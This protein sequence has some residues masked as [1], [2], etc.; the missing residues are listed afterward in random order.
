MCVHTLPASAIQLQCAC[1]C[2]FSVIPSSMVLEW[3]THLLTVFYFIHT[4]ICVTFAVIN[5]LFDSSV[6]ALPLKIW[7]QK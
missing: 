6:T 5:V 7:L 1:I 4:C 3:T 2:Y